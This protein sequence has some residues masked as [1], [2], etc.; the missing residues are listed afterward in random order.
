MALKASDM[1]E[2]AKKFLEIIQNAAHPY[3]EERWEAIE[4]YVALVGKAAIPLLKSLLEG[5]D[6]ITRV[7]AIKQIGQWLDD[8]ITHLLIDRLDDDED[9]VREK[10]REVLQRGDE[11]TVDILLARLNTENA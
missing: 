11:T 8:G 2:M 9:L 3:R 5:D 6:K 10:A 4:Q 1:D 7:V